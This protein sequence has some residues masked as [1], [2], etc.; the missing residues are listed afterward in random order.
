MRNVWEF[1]RHSVQTWL[2]AFLCL[3]G[4]VGILELPRRIKL[5]CGVN[6][7]RCY[8]TGCCLWN[9][10]FLTE[11]MMRGQP[12]QAFPIPAAQVSTTVLLLSMIW[13]QFDRWLFDGNASFM[14]C[15]PCFSM[16]LYVKL[17][18]KSHGQNWSLRRLSIDLPKPHRWEKIASA[19]VSAIVETEPLWAALFRRCA[20][21]GR[22]RSERLCRLLCSHCFGMTF[23]AYHN[24]HR[25]EPALVW[26]EQISHCAISNSVA[27]THQI[28]P[29]TT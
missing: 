16:S 27:I 1:E 4:G 17:S 13:C 7:T 9:I 6:F 10:F 22:F 5:D 14:D 18:E 8:C 12:D 25:I 21:K 2:A 24:G 28:N 3:V 29:T 11:R 19:E 26:K 23:T 20:A 15:P